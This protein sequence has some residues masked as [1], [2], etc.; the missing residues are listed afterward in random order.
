MK[1]K[2]IELRDN[3]S[4]SFQAQIVQNKLALEVN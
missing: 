3:S 4:G 2:N 1:M